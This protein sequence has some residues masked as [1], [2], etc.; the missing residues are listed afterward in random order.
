MYQKEPNSKGPR[1]TYL[2]GGEVCHAR[3]GLF[4][5]LSNPKYHVIALFARASTR[6]P[7]IHFDKHIVGKNYGRAV[8]RRLSVRYAA[9]ARR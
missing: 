6:A 7:A 9:P 8:T 5:R 2:F 4:R 1:T 3:E